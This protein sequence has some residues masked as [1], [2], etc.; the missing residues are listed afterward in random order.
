MQPA[1]RVDNV[2]YSQEETVEVKSIGNASG[3]RCCYWFDIENGLKAMMLVA[4]VDVI[5]TLGN[6][7]FGLLFYVVGK[8]NEVTVNAATG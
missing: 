2:P 3:V 6:L 4:I 7:F 1:K 5:Y 8:S